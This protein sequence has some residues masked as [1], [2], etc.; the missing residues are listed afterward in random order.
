MKVAGEIETYSPRVCQCGHLEKDHDLYDAVSRKRMDCLVG[1]FKGMEIDAKPCPC[2]NF[3]LED[4]E[5][6][7]EWRKI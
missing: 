1:I 2:S 3:S 7:R 5:G 4:H 6:D